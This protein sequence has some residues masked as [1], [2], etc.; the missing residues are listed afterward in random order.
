MQQIQQTAL[1][2]KETYSLCS[3]VTLK[4][5]RDTEF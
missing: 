3:Y 4:M 5:D 1:R 2:V